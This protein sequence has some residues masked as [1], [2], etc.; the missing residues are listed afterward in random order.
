VQVDLI[1]KTLEENLA[2]LSKQREALER[3]ELVLR[4]QHRQSQ[5]NVAYTLGQIAQ[6]ER[7]LQTLG[8]EA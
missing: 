8:G 2:A 5:V 3:A 7:T 6:A 1:K 4:E